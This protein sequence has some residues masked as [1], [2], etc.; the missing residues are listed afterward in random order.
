M[1]KIIIRI[2]LICI[3][4]AVVALYFYDLFVNNAPPTHNLFRIC[5][6]ICLCIAAYIRTFQSKYRKSLNFYELQYSEILKNAFQTQPFWK[7]KLLCAVR[8]YN[9]SKYDKA[10]DYLMDLKQRSETREDHYAT[11]LFAGLCFTDMGLYE[12]A[13]KIYEQSIDMDIAD[14]RIFSNLGHVEMK[15]GEYKK[16]LQHY[17]IALEYNRRNEFAL[18]NIAQAHFQMHEF[19]EAIEFALKALDINPKL[20]QASTLLA[21]TYAL[22]GDKDNSEKYFHI[23]INSGRDP[24]EIKE[25]IEYF[26]TA[27][28]ALDKDAVAENE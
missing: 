17:E 8:L 25:A 4:L 21:I 3:V 11:N 12:H 19:D 18:N 27:Q 26:R 1:K 7:K 23:A 5:S 28:H 20:G 6:L 16:A 13:A 9:E 2:L 14:S 10:L 15:L 24:K 22:L